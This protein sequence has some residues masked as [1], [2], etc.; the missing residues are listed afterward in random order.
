MPVKISQIAERAGLSRQTVS[1]ILNGKGHLFAADTR[2]KVSRI[3]REMGYRPNAV[4]RAL[5]SGRFN[6][7]G[8]VSSMQS[9]AAGSISLSALQGIEEVAANHNFHLVS[10]R[11]SD[12]KLSGADAA[13]KILRELLVDGLIINYTYAVP[14]AFAEQMVGLS[15][16]PS[17]WFNTRRE[18]DCVRPDDFQGGEI[19]TEYLLSMGHRRIAYLDPRRTEDELLGKGEIAHH[20]SVADRFAG[21]SKTMRAAGL[22][23]RAICRL[24]HLPSKQ[25]VI[26]LFLEAM[27]RKDRPTALVCA[28]E[29]GIGP[30]LL[31]LGDLG[32]KVPRDLSLA[33]F[34][35][36]DYDLAGLPIDH[37]LVPHHKAG[38]T[39]V[40]LLLNK[41]ESPAVRFPAEILACEMRRLRST[42][43]PAPAL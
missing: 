37:V 1:N 43:A 7:V 3:S 17:I 31:A 20:Y 28:A 42:V 18:F 26:P 38:R 25:E 39:A 8:L 16:I 14:A 30:L 24:P 35:D 9:H 12:E 2:E 41:I 32:L 29:Y 6:A 4:A 23:P 10:G 27:A 19:V 34:A 36:R 33:V 13:P 22:E 40:E 5:R 15:Q 11:F 21:Y